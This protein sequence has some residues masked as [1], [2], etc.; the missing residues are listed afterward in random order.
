M[1][2]YPYFLLFAAIY[3][4]ISLYALNASEVNLIYII[5]PLL[6]SLVGIGLIFGLLLLI[7]RSPQKAAITSAIGFLIFCSYGALFNV[8]KGLSIG[9]VTF[10]NHRILLPVVVILTAIILWFVITRVK[11]PYFQIYQGFNFVLGALILFSIVQLGL[12]FNQIKLPSQAKNTQSNE[13]SQAATA[14]PDIYYFML[15]SY[16]RADYIKKFMEYDNTPFLDS[17]KQRGFYIADCSMS[18][19]SFTRLSQATTLNMEYFE[20]LGLNVSRDDKDESKMDPYILHPKI[21]TDL[22][23]AGYSTVAFET[24]YPFTEWSDADY[25]FRSESNPLTMPVLTAF[26]NMLIQNTGVSA[27]LNNQRIRRALGFTFPY[28]EKWSREHYII[29][30]MKNVPDLPGPK[31]VYIHLVTTHRPYV[32]T[33]DGS[34]LNDERYY[35]NDGVPIDDEFY[36]RGF[37]YQ[38]E[39]TNNYMLGLIDTIIANSKL[40]PVIILQ[41]D[42]GVRAPGRHSILNAL[43]IPNLKDALYPSISPVN[44]FRVVENSV[45]G[46]N[47]DLLE[48]STYF[49][50]TNVAPYKLRPIPNDNPC[51]IQ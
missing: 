30:K 15:D 7:L 37:Q 36:I 51:K 26:E 38:L 19:Y 31:F 50:N 22:E 42:H 5:R 6:A 13:T 14:K 35:L 10:G 18:N 11:P 4:V 24:G 17:L 48:D 27:A 32:F 45:L 49:S 12:K 29:D 46:T 3:P 8:T 1:K 41:G 23:K 28:Y 47:L 20:N 34:I 21:R 39:F 44:N 9:G 33:A 25:F 16:P 43:L 2:K 40:P